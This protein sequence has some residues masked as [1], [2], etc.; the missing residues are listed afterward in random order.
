MSGRAEDLSRRLAGMIDGEIEAFA[1]WLAEQW[2]IAPHEAESAEM[3]PDQ[4]EGWN[5]CVDSIPAAFALWLED[6]NR[7]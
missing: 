7:V 2:T 5:R 1:A 3:T 6:D 4:V